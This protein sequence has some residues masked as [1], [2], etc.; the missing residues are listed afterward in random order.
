MCHDNAAGFITSSITTDPNV[1]KPGT[2]LYYVSMYDS[3][4]DLSLFQDIY[5]SRILHNGLE[6]GLKL[7]YHLRTEKSESLLVTLKPYMHK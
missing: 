6:Y 5:L 4:V 2:E 7:F 3:A 1:S